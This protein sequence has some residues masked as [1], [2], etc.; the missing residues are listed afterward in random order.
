MAVVI[1]GECVEK[2]W[3]GNGKVPGTNKVN[4]VANGGAHGLGKCE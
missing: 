3:E 4:G 1:D 2:R